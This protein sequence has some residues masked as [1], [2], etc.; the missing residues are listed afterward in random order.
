[1]SDLNQKQKDFVEY[2]ILT[3]NPKEAAIMAGY[4]EEKAIKKGHSF[5]KNK[6]ISERIKERMAFYASNLYITN[7]FIVNKLLEI[8]DFS[9]EK[10]FVLNKDGTESDRCKYRDIT[11]A[12]KALIFLSKFTNE[13]T[14]KSETFERELSIENLDIEKI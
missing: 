5:L 7:S 10:E 8:I 1:M 11:S 4:P 12:L 9:L 2:Y 13:S 3:L 6:R 14:K